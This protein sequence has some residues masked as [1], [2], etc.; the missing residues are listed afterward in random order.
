LSQKWK[1]SLKARSAT[2]FVIP[3]KSYGWKFEAFS[4]ELL[5]TREVISASK[6]SFFAINS[7]TLSTDGGALWSITE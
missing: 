4:G 1:T 2:R 5:A 6:S 3:S 7:M